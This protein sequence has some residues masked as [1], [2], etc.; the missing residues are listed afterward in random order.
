M[1]SYNCTC[2]YPQYWGA[3]CDFNK[4]NYYRT[5]SPYTMELC[6]QKDREANVCELHGACFWVLF[7]P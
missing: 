2:K 4:D 5:E 7:L 1:G 6:Q 3:K